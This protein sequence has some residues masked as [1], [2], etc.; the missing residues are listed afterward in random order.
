MYLT[1]VYDI[2]T[3]STCTHIHLK[4]SITMESIVKVEIFSKIASNYSMKVVGNLKS[5][6]T[7]L[8]FFGGY[9]KSCSR[10]IF[11]CTANQKKKTHTHKNLHDKSA[12][13]VFFP[14]KM[15]IFLFCFKLF[16]C[17]DF[18]SSGWIHWRKWNCD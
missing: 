12:I 14:L 4:Y 18:Y 9:F 11:A 15:C 1:R 10:Q 13:I 6:N 8:F 7:F 5:V 3:S 2:C 17:F 16:Y